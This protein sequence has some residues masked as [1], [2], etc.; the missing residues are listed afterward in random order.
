MCHRHRR[1]RVPL[2][3]RGGEDSIN[4]AFT[5]QGPG[6]SHLRGTSAARTTGCLRQM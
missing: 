1:I 2:A 5:V 3:L 6:M 4:R